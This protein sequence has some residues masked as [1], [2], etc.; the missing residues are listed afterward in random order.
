MAIN[1]FEGGRRINSLLMAVV[2]LG[3]ATHILFGGSSMV[4]VFS[5]APDEQWYFAP[6]ECDYPNDT[7]Y[8]SEGSSPELSGISVALCFLTEKG[9]IYYSEALPPQDAQEH[10]VTGPTPAQKWYWHGKTYDQD[11]VAYTDKRKAEFA[12][13]PD[14]IRQ[15]QEGTW[16]LRWTRFIS[17]IKDAAPFV[18]GFIFS[19]WMLA[20]LIGWIVRGFAGIPSGQDFRSTTPKDDSN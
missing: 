9:E 16:R 19:L 18:L 13:T 4:Y 8:P 3:G 5:S 10:K 11:V 17:R 14:L 20:A 15:I 12:L 7:E 6:R 1:W 2:A